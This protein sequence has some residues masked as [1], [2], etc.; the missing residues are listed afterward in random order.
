M[1]AFNNFNEF[2]EKY[3]DMMNKDKEYSSLFIKHIYH[4]N[5]YKKSKIWLKRLLGIEDFDPQNSTYG[6]TLSPILE[7]E[8]LCPMISQVDIKYRYIDGTIQR[9]RVLPI[10]IYHY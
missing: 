1:T 3:E 2:E 5:V 10:D 6:F 8:C 7:V 9:S 4:I